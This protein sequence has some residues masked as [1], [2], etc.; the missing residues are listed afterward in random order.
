M[1][2]DRMTNIV[3]RRGTVASRTNM[4]DPTAGDLDGRWPIAP[5]YDFLD[6]AEL[7]RDPMTGDWF[8]T[9]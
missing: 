6:L 1:N 8:H 4:S 9:T 7:E 5:R 2:E 3:T